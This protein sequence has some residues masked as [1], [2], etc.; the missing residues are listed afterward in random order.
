MKDLFES[1]IED[2]A[3]VKTYRKSENE[4]RISDKRL[5]INDKGMSFVRDRKFYNKMPAFEELKKGDWLLCFHDKT[6][7]EFNGKTWILEGII[8]YNKDDN[9]TVYSS[10]DNVPV[11]D[12]NPVL[13][14]ADIGKLP[15]PISLVNAFNINHPETDIKDFLCANIDYV[16]CPDIPCIT[17]KED[18]NLNLSAFFESTTEYQENNC[19]LGNDFF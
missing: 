15:I 3:I 17:K 2:S 7:Y 19:L 16:I 9:V 6:G 11:T 1:L 10:I 5:S 12:I 8:G 13:S 14:N 4:V 18:R